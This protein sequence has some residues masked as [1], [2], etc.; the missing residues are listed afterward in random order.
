MNTSLV[1]GL[2]AVLALVA[3]AG[4]GAMVDKQ[5][6][7]PTA[8]EAPAST[9]DASTTLSDTPTS[10]SD[11]PRIAPRD[12]RKLIKDGEDVAIVDTRSLRSYEISHIEG[13]ISL[14][15]EEIGE[16]HTELPDDHII[17]LYCT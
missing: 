16:R 4:C 10:A 5:P 11:A 17:I 12:V 3:L 9:P 1:R 2:I 14:P 8:T 7:S 13:A 6:V 15:L